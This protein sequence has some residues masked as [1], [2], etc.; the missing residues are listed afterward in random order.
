MISRCCAAA[1]A[2][3]NIDNTVDSF[4]RDAKADARFRRNIV[5]RLPISHSCYG[6]DFD[7]IAD[8]IAFGHAEPCCW[9][10]A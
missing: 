3:A 1:A 4:Q 2:A 7:G 10:Y 8:A 6:A 5:K 9:A